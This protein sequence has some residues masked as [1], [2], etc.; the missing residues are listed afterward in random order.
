[1]AS[2]RDER[3]ARSL[4]AES[5]IDGGIDR[6]AGSEGEDALLSAKPSL[7]DAPEDAPDPESYSDPQP[8][9][10]TVRPASAI[11]YANPQRRNCAHVASSKG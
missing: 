6:V 1:M 9:R 3:G 10:P 7:D 11:I 2:E 8:V 4:D 5:G